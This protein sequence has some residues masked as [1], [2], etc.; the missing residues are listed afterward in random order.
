MSWEGLKNILLFSLIV[1]SGLLTWSYWF[2]QPTYEIDSSQY[3]Q[4]KIT[5]NGNMEPDEVVQPVKVLYHTRGSYYG[6]YSEDLVTE[7]MDSIKRFN[8]FNFRNQSEKYDE[9]AIKE[10]MEQDGA[11]QVIFNDQVPLSFYKKYLK[12]EDSSVPVINFDR[13]M[14]FTESSGDNNHAVYFI[15]KDQGTVVTA[16]LE[17]EALE[18]FASSYAKTGNFVRYENIT[19]TNQQ[20]VIVPAGRQKVKGYSYLSKQVPASSFKKALFSTPDTVKQEGDIYTDGSSLMKVNSKTSMIEYKNLAVGAKEEKNTDTHILQRSIDWINTHAGWDQRYRYA[21]MDE[22][23]RDILYRLYISGLPV[24]NDAG[25]S[26]FD[27]EWGTEN[28]KVY[29]RPYVYLG[30]KPLTQSE[31]TLPA[32]EDALTVFKE[33][34]SKQ[35]NPDKLSDMTIGYMMTVDDSTGTDII[36][37]KPT[38]YFY[39]DQSWVTITDKTKGGILDGLE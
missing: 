22:R 8:L 21:A 17:T 27:V 20:S 31:N 10:L 13:I 39:Y 11:I 1:I 15:S 4:T 9:D 37:L 24:F 29:E 6:T 23:N 12:I 28:V 38:W 36:A 16:A 18:Q 30:E 5:S 34:M 3:V 7:M 25:I 35:Y 19:I 26:E 2:Y 33:S 14:V 32:A